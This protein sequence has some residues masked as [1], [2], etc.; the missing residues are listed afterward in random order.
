MQMNLITL[1]VQPLS[2]ME[3]GKDNRKGSKVENINLKKKR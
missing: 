1:F 3:K 2:R